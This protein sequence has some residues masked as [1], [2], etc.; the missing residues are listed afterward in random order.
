MATSGYSGPVSVCSLRYTPVAGHKPS[1]GI[2]RFMA[3]NRDMEVRLAIPAGARVALLVGATVPM[4]LGTATIELT[5]LDV[6]SGGM[7]TGGGRL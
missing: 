2:V 5:R 1:A 3:A 6:E 7:V 4:Q